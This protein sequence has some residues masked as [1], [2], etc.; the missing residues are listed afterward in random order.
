M[1]KFSAILSC[2]YFLC[3]RP[4]GMTATRARAFTTDPK[5]QSIEENAARLASP[6]PRRLIGNPSDKPEARRSGSR[7]SESRDPSHIPSEPTGN[8]KERGP[9][10]GRR[11][12]CAIKPVGHVS[13][14]KLENR[15]SRHQ[16]LG[17]EHPPAAKRGVT[18]PEAEPCLS[19]S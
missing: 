14:L 2:V 17:W 11:L 6:P 19:N 16:R 4:S 12:G 13:D 10:T 9:Q 3:F 15:Q 1:I 5:P 8:R 18:D 7:L